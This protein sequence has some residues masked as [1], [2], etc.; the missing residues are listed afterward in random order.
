VLLEQGVPLIE[1]GIGDGHVCHDS[2]GAQ[3]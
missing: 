3:L 1:S 2:I